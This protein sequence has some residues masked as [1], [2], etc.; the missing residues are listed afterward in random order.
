MKTS[1]HDN[2][3][4]HRILAIAEHLFLKNKKNKVILISKDINL[5]MK[6]KSLGIPAEDYKNDQVQD[7]EDLIS[8]GITTI[9]NF[10]D[11]KI[12]SLYRS[13]TGISEEEFNFGRPI[14]GHEYFILKNNS[15]SALAHYDPIEKSSPELKNQMPM[16]FF[17]ETLSKPF[18]YMP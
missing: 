14:I 13:N 11:E 10:D 4:D 12:S 15:S 5:R 3:P 8:L 9:D 1:F 6:A 18:L 2:I 16:E 17:H 7:L